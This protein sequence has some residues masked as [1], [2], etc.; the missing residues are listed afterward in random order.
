MAVDDATK[1]IQQP[2]FEQGGKIIGPQHGCS[3]ATPRV[4]VA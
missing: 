1:V 4:G 3:F 2:I